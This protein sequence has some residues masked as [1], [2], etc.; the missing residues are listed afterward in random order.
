M[1]TAAVESEYS[2]PSSNAGAHSSKAARY[3]N[4]RWTNFILYG[5]NGY[6]NASVGSQGR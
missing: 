2:E 3:V 1:A 4:P 6:G 5:I